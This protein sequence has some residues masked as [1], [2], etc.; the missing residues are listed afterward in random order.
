[1]NE[2]NALRKSLRKQ[3]RAVSYFQQQQTEL[4][5]LQQLRHHVAFQ[6]SK[7][8]GI[9]LDAF[10]EVQTNK[11]IRL[12]FQLNKYVYLPMICN[13]NQRLVWVKMSKTQFENKRFTHHP[14][15]MKEPIA[16]R[17]THVSHLDYLIMP[18]LACDAFGTR[19]GMG[20]GY[21]DRT[22]ASVLCKPLRVGLAH[23]FQF[24]N[25]QLNRQP[26]DQP[27][28]TL[29]TPSKTYQFRRNYF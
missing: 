27:L 20:G 14:L 7:K 24:L 11:I 29:I 18:L 25:D 10:G 2:L 1:M 15:G 23:D 6:K 28:D 12:C 19:M 13:M 8:I 26:W 17:G 3:R 22:L 16:S 5:V 4:Q 9:Y 21:Y